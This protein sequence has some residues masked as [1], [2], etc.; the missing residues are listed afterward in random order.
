MKEPFM[1]LVRPLPC[2]MFIYIFLVY[3][4]HLLF[5]VVAATG[6]FT[7]K[8]T[9]DSKLTNYMSSHDGANFTLNLTYYTHIS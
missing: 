4:R 2:A 3:A 8:N 1:S 5:N 6:L 7:A 9:F